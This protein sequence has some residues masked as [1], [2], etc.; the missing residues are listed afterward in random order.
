MKGNL[1]LNTAS[2]LLLVL[3]A[4]QTGWQSV[5]CAE[6]AEK[7]T[8][9]SSIGKAAPAFT[10]IDSNGSKRSLADYANKIV[11]LE[12]INFDD[13][14]VMK[15]YSTGDMQKLQKTYKSKGVIW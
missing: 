8:A 10:L 11:V 5:H 4:G 7:K 1:W 12:W 15:Q 3:L 14:Y 13:P 2:T 6:P 9:E